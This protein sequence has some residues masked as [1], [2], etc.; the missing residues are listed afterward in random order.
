MASG[1]EM[2]H[3]N[4]A[5][6][7]AVTRVCI[8]LTLI[9]C[10]LPAAAA[11]EIVAHRGASYAA[12]ENT[13]A[14][15]DLA[16]RENADACEL[17][18]YLTADKQIA[19]LHDATTTRTTGVALRVRSSYLDELRRLDAGKWKSLRYT[20]EKIP[21]LAESLATMPKGK[22]FFVEVKCGAEIV[23]YLL[24]VLDASGKDLEQ[25]VVISFNADV[26][27]DVEKARP[28]LKTYYLCSP[29][30]ANA[31]KLIRIARV[32]G[33]DGINGAASKGFDESV[34][35]S[36]RAAGLGVYVWT[37]DDEAS[38]RRYAGMGVDGITTNKPAYAKSIVTTPGK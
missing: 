28:R 36:F 24:P 29:K 5:G 9:L 30:A 18:C 10:S 15:F 3:E 20:G 31:E 7:P 19:V 23:P 38:I 16:W 26:I 27:R 6:G 2:E 13:V 11:P 34:I 12:P 4:S 14:A 1:G 8:V 35:A 37:I 25:L 32:I 17:D 22:R 33:T 21:T